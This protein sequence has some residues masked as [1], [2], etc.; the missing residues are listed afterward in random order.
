MSAISQAMR[1]ICDEKGIP[2]ESVLETVEAA[3]AA[4]YRKDYGEKN[5]N[6]KAVF[7]P[8]SGAVTAFDEKEVVEDEFV[9]A[10]LAEIEERARQRELIEQ[11][12]AEG[13][14]I[15]PELE[16]V[17]AAAEESRAESGE[18]EESAEV[19]GVKKYNPKLHLAL[20]A[21]REHEVD[22]TVGDTIR[23]P[24]SV[25]GE[26]GR[27]A[28]QT[29][30]QVIMQRLREAERDTI[31]N[32]WKSHEGEL[33]TATVSRREGRVIFLELGPRATG[34]LREDEQIPTDRYAPGARLKVI[35]YAVNKTMRGSE[36]LCSRTH[37]DLIRHLFAMEV[38]E[39]SSGA[40]EIVAIAREPGSRAKV[41]VRSTEENVDPIGACIGQR[42]TRVQT[43]IAEL[44]GEKIDII[45]FADD[46]AAFIANA[47]AP[48]K[49]VRVELH[50]DQHTAVVRVPAEQFSLAIGRSGQNVR[51]AARLTGWKINVQE[52]VARAASE[53]TVTEA[54]GAAVPEAPAQEPVAMEAPAESDAGAQESEAPSESAS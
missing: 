7:N 39:V 43:I 23:I 21:A 24:L 31:Y 28:A 12:R 19:G 49:V 20:A 1:D 45:E 10:A 9:A 4:A 5:Q 3:L 8:E 22:A 36:L 53:A 17:R 46:T 38:P 47:M 25:P 42:G 29:A 33:I 2:Y 52:S 6:I 40:V 13:K 37:P 30:K 41:A 16:A 44:S 27:M 50:E 18:G 54:E 11:L 32:A 48:A 15:P 34:V 51:L 26:F 14:P 35:L